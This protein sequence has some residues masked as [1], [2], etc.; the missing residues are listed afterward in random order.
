MLSPAPQGQQR[1]G[2]EQGCC[3]GLGYGRGPAIEELDRLE[4]PV[5]GV[6][7]ALEEQGKKLRYSG[8]LVP[9]V[10]HIMVKGGGIFSYPGSRKKPAGRLRLVL[11][12]RPLAFIFEA[13][14]GMATD[15][16]VMPCLRAAGRYCFCTSRRRSWSLFF[17][18]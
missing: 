11:E 17:S 3:R 12:S 18:E 10:N 7:E 8:A 5:V 2:C 9:D 14:D 16:K 1:P 13:A 6:V 4:V 15:G